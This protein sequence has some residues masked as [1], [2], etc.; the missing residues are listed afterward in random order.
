M[1][2]T[3]FKS[4]DAYI[5]AQT[6]TSR[7]ALTRVR[8]A[9]RKALPDAEETISYKMP[10]YK[11]NGKAVLHFA[12][13]KE[14]YSIYAA[15]ARVVETFK[16]ELAPYKIDKGTIRFT[17]ARPVPVKLIARIAKF[18]AGESSNPAS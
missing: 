10:T 14:H 17:F 15:T 1:A 2:V 5:D 6:E 18:R 16:A 11:L 3:D 8:N 13:W 7:A 9:I 12:A 4:V